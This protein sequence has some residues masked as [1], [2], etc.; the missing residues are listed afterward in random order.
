MSHLKRISSSKRTSLERKGTTFLTC[1]SPGTHRKGES[2]ALNVVMRDVLGLVDTTREAKKALHSEMV[3]VNGV[4]KKDHRL[5]VGFLDEITFTSSKDTYI[6][7]YN[8]L[9][10]LELKKQDKKVTRAMKIIGKKILAKGKVQLNLFTGKN[11]ILDKKA[12]Y[13][14]GDSVVVDKEKV[15]KHL[16][17]EKGAKVFLTSGKHIGHNGVIEEITETESWLQ[18]KK[19]LV[20]TKNGTFETSKE[21]AYVL[22]GEL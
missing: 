15:T 2:M 1:Q 7:V 22:D 8:T 3:L 17:F 16:K 14:V 6:M 4:P 18:S 11:I 9:G 21:C 13:S 10:K 12:D 19:I 5:S 20:K